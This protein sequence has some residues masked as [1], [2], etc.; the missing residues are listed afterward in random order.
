[1][2]INYYRPNG[3]NIIDD[4]KKAI[5]TKQI[6]IKLNLTL[7]NLFSPLEQD[8]EMVWNLKII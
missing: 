1:M 6:I 5:S 7:T 2:F 3:W 4:I 8:T